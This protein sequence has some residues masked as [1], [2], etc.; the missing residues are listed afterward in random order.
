MFSIQ[1]NYLGAEVECSEERW[2]HIL[3]RHP[4]LVPAHWASI[5][6]T[7]S[8]PDEI[9]DDPRGP[10]SHRFTR[11]FEGIK[12]GKFVV[13]VVVSSIEPN[14]RHWIVTAFPARKPPKGRLLWKRE[15]P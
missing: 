8:D 3:Q 6:Q 4:E 11:W 1:C 5:E 12:G 2:N 7:V 10:M 9:R 14:A 15:N 13:V